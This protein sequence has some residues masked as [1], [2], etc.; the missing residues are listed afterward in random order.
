[1]EVPRLTVGD[2]PGCAL[3]LIVVVDDREVPRPVAE[4]TRAAVQGSSV[5]D[6]GRDGEFDYRVHAR[7]RAGTTMCDTAITVPR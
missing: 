2:Q 3:G 7:S 1:V 6:C 5:A 4:P